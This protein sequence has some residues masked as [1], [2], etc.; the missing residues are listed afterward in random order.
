MV[1]KMVEKA[2]KRF[3]EQFQNPYYRQEPPET[4]PG[5]TYI[6]KKQRGGEV[7]DAEFEELD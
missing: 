4:E 6:D 2:Q 5:K 7:E 1:K 3:E